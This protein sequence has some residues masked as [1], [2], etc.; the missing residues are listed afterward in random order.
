MASWG[1]KCSARAY[2][3]SDALFHRA[4]DMTHNMHVCT[5]GPA[6]KAVNLKHYKSSSARQL[7]PN[8]DS[9]TRVVVVVV[10]Q[11]SSVCCLLRRKGLVMAMLMQ[12]TKH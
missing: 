10:A 5:S 7:G 2:G 12:F 11:R 4:C 9:S 1:W 8:A 6:L 3:A